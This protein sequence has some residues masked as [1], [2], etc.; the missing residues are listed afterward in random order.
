MVGVVESIGDGGL[1]LVVGSD[2]EFCREGRPASAAPNR[3]YQGWP[4]I[5]RRQQGQG[6]LLP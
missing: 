6:G 4:K 1:R 3:G 2:V 5:T